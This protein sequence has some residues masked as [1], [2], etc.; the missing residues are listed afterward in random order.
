MMLF[1]EQ[2]GSMATKRVVCVKIIGCVE[3]AFPCYPNGEPEA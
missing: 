3:A 2:G 1:L